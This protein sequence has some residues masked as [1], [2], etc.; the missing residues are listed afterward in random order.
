MRRKSKITIENCQIKSADKFK[1]VAQAIDTI[2]IETFVGSGLIS[3]VGMFICPDIDLLQFLKSP[4]ATERLLAEICIQ[5]HVKQ[6][7]KNS[8]PVYLEASKQIDDKLKKRKAHLKK[9]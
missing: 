2:E 9:C 4:N 6:Y 7:G 5:L 8:R 1:A 3:F